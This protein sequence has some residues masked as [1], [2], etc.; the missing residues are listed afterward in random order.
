MKIVL[1]ISLFVFVAL[2]MSIYRR[3]RP[4]TSI[5][6]HVMRG[7]EQ[8]TGYRDVWEY[9]ADNHKDPYFGFLF[10]G[11]SAALMLLIISLMVVIFQSRG[12]M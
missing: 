2:L 8:S 11:A 10:L 3:G 4:W 12:I 9:W 5:P 6:E 7:Y 1:V